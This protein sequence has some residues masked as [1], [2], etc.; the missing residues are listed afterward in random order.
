MSYEPAVFDKTPDEVLDYNLSF[1]DLLSKLNDTIA[2]HVVE[3]KTGITIDSS[4]NTDD[5]V[6]LWVSG[7]ESYRSY[8]GKVTITTAGGRV[9]EQDVVFVVK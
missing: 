4:S 1:S 7:G 8:I 6:T 3:M 2:S 9:R 5:S